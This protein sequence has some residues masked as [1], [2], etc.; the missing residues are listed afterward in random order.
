M[1][2]L[3]LEESEEG[4]TGGNGLTKMFLILSEK[5]YLVPNKQSMVSTGENTLTTLS[6]CLAHMAHLLSSSIWQKM[7]LL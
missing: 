2:D 6:A 5:K 7:C 1:L 3:S 4:Y